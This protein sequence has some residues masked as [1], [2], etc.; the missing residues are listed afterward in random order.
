M[1]K[2]LSSLWLKSFK[3]FSKVQQRQGTELLRSLLGTP[4]PAKRKRTAAKPGASTGTGVVKKVLKSIGLLQAP[5]AS[6]AAVRSAP[7]PKTP[8]LRV[9]GKPTRAVKPAAAPQGRWLR[10]FY[11]EPAEG[12]TPPRRMDYWLFVPSRPLAEQKKPMPLVVMLHGCAQTAADFAHGTRMNVLAQRKGFA[13]LYPQQLATVDH[14][15]CWHWHLRATQQGGGEVR[16]VVGAIKKVMKSWP[17]DASRVY[18][19]GL[20]AGAALA[21]IVALRHPQ[22]VAAVGLH[23]APVF[24]TAD[25]RMGAFSAMQHGSSHSL[26]QAVEEMALSPEFPGMPAILLQGDADKVVRS[27]NLMQ[28]AQQFRLVNH[29]DEM[30]HP[31]VA[32]DHPA[33]LVGSSP[34]HGYQVLDYVRG[35]TSQV[36]VCRIHGL[37]HAWSGGDSQLRFNAEVGPD[38][39]LMMWNFFQMHRRVA[40]IGVK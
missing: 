18:V 16:W 10:S 4:A 26:A 11:L 21:Q 23:S 8:K 1:R 36:R 25:S 5:N 27:V 28:L 20:S 19:A 14:N 33:R 31:P 22:L 15:R 7:A 32:Q 38:A 9:A 17:I 2:S 37:D 12:M 24:G 34:R 3:R 40:P 29:I 6:R 39:S 35:R 13:V 30:A